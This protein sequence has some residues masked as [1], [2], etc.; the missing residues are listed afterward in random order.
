MVPTT[1]ILIILG[2]ITA[3][4]SHGQPCLAN[5][6]AEEKQF[7]HLGRQ[8]EVVLS[9]RGVQGESR[10]SEIE[11]VKMTRLCAG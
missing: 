4:S 9:V 7:F 6:R 8:R 1:C 3:D 2:I 10:C 11:S 5:T